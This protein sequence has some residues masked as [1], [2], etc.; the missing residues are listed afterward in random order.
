[1]PRPRWSLAPEPGPEASLLADKLGVSPVTAALLA[2]RLPGVSPE[3][4]R[5]FLEPSL[6]DLHSPWDLPDMKIAAERLAKAVSADEK[7]VVH[8]DY[9]TDG[10]TACAVLL[11]A[12]AALGCKA[13][14]YLP[15]RFEG[16][17]GLSD[18]FVRLATERGVDLVVTVDCGTSEHDR[19][20]ALLDA[21]VDVI[22]TDHHEPGGIELP[23]AL[24]VVNPKREDSSYPFRELVGVGVAFKLVWA[25]CQEVQGAKKVGDRLQRMLLSLLPFVAV[26]TVADVAPLVGENRILVT[27]G[28]RSLRRSCSGLQALLDISRTRGER[29][30]ARDIGF[31]L[32][33]R[34]NAA[35]R[36]G[37]ADL[38]LSLLIE[39]DPGRARDQAK[40]LDRANSSRQKLCQT[41]EAEAREEVAGSFDPA[42]DGAIVVGGDGWH[43]GVIGIVAGRLAEAYDRPV[44]V[45]A[46]EPGEDTGRGSARSIDGLDLFAAMSRSRPR[47]LTFG[48][49]EQ[50][51]GFTIQRDEVGPLRNEL[52]SFCHAQLE[53]GAVQPSLNVDRELDFTDLSLSLAREL[54]QLSPFGKGN[55]QPRFMSRNIRIAGKPRLL[56]SSGRH[57]S[58]NASQE[59]VAYRAVVFNRTDWLDQMDAG[60]ACWD[61]VFT[62]ELNHFGTSPRAELKVVDMHPS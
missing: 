21:G 15:S 47:F 59:E 46:F 35:G 34:L 9:D 57:F 4:A 17:Y 8:G 60:V 32:A 2:Q 27:H 54:E 56:G 20:R 53:S 38:A 48:G 13:E 58:F 61:M 18:E 5:V 10:V 7:V 24:G 43:Q 1:M 31:S 36:M 55:P 3:S 40:R 30:T 29:L 62:L 49:H 22:V 25:L 19:I 50:A 41:I 52:S 11:R 28:L 16:G 51:A 14:P 33:P 23:P 37:E 6:A 12:L 42:R 26:G 39:E 44:L 45:I